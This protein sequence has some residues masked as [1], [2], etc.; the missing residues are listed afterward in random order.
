MDEGKILLAKLPHGTIGEENSYLLGTLLV[1]KF[2]QVV[3]GRQRQE[4]SQRRPFWLYLDEFHNFV[5]P[6]MASILSGARK[7]KLGLILAHQDL[8]QLS[9]RDSEVES[10]VISNPYTRVCFRLGDQDARKLSEGFTHFD[11]NDLQSLGI[12]E[13]IARVERSDSDFNLLTDLVPP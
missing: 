2:Y 13:A 12:G 11:S 8:K 10:S 7:Y 1:T 5:T 9:S 6:S 4:A 3:M